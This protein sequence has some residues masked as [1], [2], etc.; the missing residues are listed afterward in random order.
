MPTALCLRRVLLV[1][2]AGLALIA[3]TSAPAHA[4]LEPS[5][6]CPGPGVR[7]KTSNDPRVY[8]VSPNSTLY[9]IPGDVYF[10][11]WDSWDGIVIIDYLPS[12]PYRLGATLTDGHLHKK[13]DRPEVYIYDDYYGFDRWITSQAVFDKYRFSASKIY[14]HNERVY[15][16]LPDWN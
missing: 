13:R 9:Y 11:L 10:N 4:N 5:L 2:F 1:L 14:V 16:R 12:C 7:V 8:L 3:S 15:N 6:D